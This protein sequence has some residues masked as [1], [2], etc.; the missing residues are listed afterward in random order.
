MGVDA[1]GVTVT[2]TVGGT[3]EQADNTR[4]EMMIKGKTKQTLFILAGGI[5]Q[6]Y[7]TISELVAHFSLFVV[8][9]II[10]SFLYSSLM[11][12]SIH[13]VMAILKLRK[14]SLINPKRY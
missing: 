9:R 4:S 8:L 5:Y 1:D 12:L 6:D 10:H 7:N 14:K 3:V 2:V 11:P 13:T